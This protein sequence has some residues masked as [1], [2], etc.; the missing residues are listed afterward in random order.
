MNRCYRLVWNRACQVFVVASEVSHGRGKAGRTVRARHLAWLAALPLS[1]SPM[2]GM[3]AAPVA[4]SAAMPMPRMALPTPPVATAIVSSTAS[5]SGGQVTVGSGNISQSGL[6]TTIN[7]HSQNLSLNWQSFNIGADSTVNFVQPNAQS[8]AV[9]RI[10]DAN[11]SVILGRLN[12]NGQVFLINPNGVLFGQGAQ[13][14][15]GGLVASTLDIDDG[16]LAGGTRHF[17]GNDSGRGSVVNRGTINAAKGG[18]VAL[19]GPQVTNQGTLNAPGGT[20]ALAGGNA[21]TLSFDG[22]RLLSLQVDKS[23]LNALA[24]NRQL[25]VADGGQVLMSAGAKDSLLASV[26]NNSGTIQAQ[27]VENRAGKIVLLGGMAAGTTQVAGTLDASAPNGGNG[28]F[29]ETSAAYVDVANDANVTTLA[30][31]GQIGK[32][33]IDPNDFTIASSGG[34]MTGA[35]VSGALASNDF[36]IATASMGTAGGHGD[37]FVNDTV[38]WSGNTFTLNAERNIAINAPLLGSGTGKLALKYGQGA[39]AAANTATYQIDAPVDLAEGNNFS[40]LLGSDGVVVPYQVITRLGA[41]GS[42]TGADLQ[43][44]GGNLAGNYALGANIDASATSSWNGGAGFDPI[45]GSGTNF[46]GAFDGLGH[47][48]STLTVNRPSENEVGLF[49]Q[50]SNADIRNVG[51]PGSNITGRTYVGALVANSQGGTTT[52]AWSSGAVGGYSWVGG[53][54]GLHNGGYV[55][56]AHSSA[57]VVGTSQL[58]GGLIGQAR[59]YGAVS[60]S[61]ATG[62][63]SASGATNV[64]G[65]IGQLRAVELSDSYATGAV[66]G[67]S[68]VGGL[69]GFIDFFSGRGTTTGSYATGAVSGDYY[70]G[71]LVGVSSGAIVASYASGAVSGSDVV[72]GLVGDNYGSITNSYWDSYS[73]GQSESVYGYVDPGTTAVTSDPSQS[74]AVDYAFRQSAYTGFDFT[75]GTGAWFMLDGGTRPFLQSEYSTTIRNTHQLQLMAMNLGASYTLGS[76]I[77]AAVTGSVAGVGSDMWSSSGFVP[78]G[79]SGTK[80]TGTFDGQGH[81]ISNL[82]INLPATQYVGLFGWTMGST[83]RNVGLVDGSVTGKDAVGGLVGSNNGSISTSYNTGTVTATGNAA[84]GL[85]GANGD[86]IYSAIDNSYATGAVTG[87]GTNVY[88]GGLS[89]VLHY[90]DINN[91][92]ATGDVINGADTIGGLVGFVYSASLRNSYSTGAVTGTSNVG[93]LVGISFS[94]ITNSYWNTTANAGLPGIGSGNTTGATG[95]TTAEMM[96]LASF[97]NLDIANTGGSNAVWRIYEGH[98]TPL[99]RSFMTNL[100][101][102]TNDVTTTYNG[103]AFS[104]STDYTFGALNPSQWLPSSSINSGLLSGTA[105]TTAPAINAGSYALDSG[106]YSGQ[107]GY[108]IMFTGGALTI[109]PAALTISSSDVSK[110]YD[111]TAA[112]SG[113]LIISN[114]MLFGGD[115]LSGGSFSFADKNAGTGKHVTVSGVTANDGNG[116]GN[117]AISYID[118][119]TSTILAKAITSVAGLGA[120]NKIYDGNTSA[121]LDLSGTLFAGIIAGD[122]LSVGT[123]TAN[124]SDKNAAI[125]KTVT[126]NGITLAGDDAGNYLLADTSAGTT[127]NI[128]QLGITVNATGSDKVYDGTTADVVAL[129]SAGVLSGDVVSF[130]GTGSFADKHVGTAKVVS[131]S[132]IAASGADVGNY[133]YNAT[134]STTADISQ[135][136]IRVDATG[137]DRIY[138]GSTADAVSLASSGIL[139]GDTVV[140]TGTGSFADKHV[141]TAKVVSVSDIAASGADAGN[142]SYNTAAGTTADITP[143]TLTYRADGA[144]F[145]TGQIPGDLGG[146]VTGLVGG[147]TLIDATDGTLIWSTPATSASPAGQYAIDGSGLSAVNYVFVQAPGNA[148]ALRVANS[149]VPAVVG[150][151]VAGL[152][153]DEVAPDSG[154]AT[155][156]APDVRVVGGGVRLP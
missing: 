29:I 15:V 43:G 89:G 45:G 115:S 77:D 105:N 84:G 53:L 44:V 93:G 106:L 141:G 108:D 107:M 73:S 144:F 72:G 4:I 32:W 17:G 11:G 46:S 8:I 101:V 92:Y 38:S 76:N 151:V 47:T 147:D 75:P 128:S 34:N 145:W 21:V 5:P 27:T 48:I 41:E 80:F 31:S 116:G 42:A 97:S 138:D 64:G 7:Q 96:Q 1:L 2:L 13:V 134:A 16:Q 120:F 142:Y 65:L 14:N 36:E 59:F 51:L 66:T 99:L 40:T 153:Q 139:A 20:V 94:A 83:I 24:D 69:I 126:I 129:A 25:I 3:A 100:S 122:D 28:G 149:S 50:T 148:M 146:A 154:V 37:I 54:I 156:R 79:N 67:G 104:G 109:N 118:N 133:S 90:G 113:T 85:V 140:F 63:V 143:A 26:V 150:A 55:T 52:N 78:I 58:V 117:Y 152:Q 112:A 12:A 68:Q 49:A 88:L 111:G 123:A 127:A 102:T 81:T 22:N 114:G 62:N 136:G 9:N 131:V 132:D 56:Q 23:T 86:D 91:S 135:L 121:T 10:A 57:E 71:G 6:T 35:A 124:F 60:D 70:V 125:G 18:Y 137:T 61:Y 74:G 98:T 130:T 103:T 110:T 30:A 119:I 95:L 39:V 33:L 82:T 87:N 19:L 155:R